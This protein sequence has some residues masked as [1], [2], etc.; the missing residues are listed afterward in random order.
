MT[1]FSPVRTGPALALAAI[2]L[3][4]G[5]TAAVAQAGSTLNVCPSGCTYAT[6]QSAVDAAT[7]GDTVVVAAGT[8]AEVVTVGKDLTLRGAQSGVAGEAHTGGES[9]VTGVHVTNANVTID[10]FEVRPGTSNAGTGII[11]HGGTT[12]IVRNSVLTQYDSSGAFWAT[13]SGT[14]D[15]S[16]NAVGPATGT[17]ADGLQVQN[18]VTAGTATISDNV[19]TDASTGGGADAALSFGSSTGTVVSGNRSTG[20]ETLVALFNSADAEISGNT[21]AGDPS[22]SGSILYV[23]GNDTGTTISGNTV[24]GASGGGVAVKNSFGYGANAGTT[25]T[26]NTLANNNYGVDVGAGAIAATDTVAAHGNVVTGNTTS[27]RNLSD[28]AVDAAR[29]WFGSVAR[30]AALAGVT[31]TP[32]CT[33]SSCSTSSD[34]ASLVG[35]S[36]SAGSLSFASAT[37]SYAVGVPD[38]VATIAVTATATP[39][40]DAVVTGAGSLAVG[41]NT[42]HVAVTSADGT[43]TRTYTVTVT[44]AAPAAP[45]ATTTTATTTTTASPPPVTTAATTPAVNTPAAA[46]AAP[47]A[48]GAVRVTVGPPT[49]G[50]GS[51]GAA[52]A[53]VT[54]TVAWTPT[55]FTE[56]VTVALTPT[57]ETTGAGATPPAVAGGFSVGPTVV[58]LSVTTSGG[59]AVTTFQAPLVIHLSAREGGDVPAYSRDGTSWTTI[60]RLPAPELPDGKQ[61]G[62]FVQPD[63]SIDIYTRHA[64]FFGLLVDTVGPAAPALRAS[65]DSHGL[66]LS[67]RGARDNVGVARYRIARDGRAVETTLRTTVVLKARAGRWTVTALDAAGNVGAASNRVVVQRGRHGLRVRR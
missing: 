1:R 25:I 26:G 3:V 24:S 20:G 65:I 61:D 17:V 19:F 57:A 66:R 4:V 9:V 63:G 54:V 39:G 44:R 10:G 28:G 58:Q 29:N 42:I 22:Y 55:A 37:T 56:P 62:Y 41:D 45:Q 31:T 59:T 52:G 40:A 34:D 67:W 18:G 64:T 46:A 47:G 38:T 12:Q 11:I 32:W 43:A 35:L 51:V 36:L 49:A 21:F 33:D 5:L 7:A 23:G 50:P 48:S 6:V 8:Y 53:P 27:I 13:G 60:P 14:L 15:F 16:R 2:G 30:P